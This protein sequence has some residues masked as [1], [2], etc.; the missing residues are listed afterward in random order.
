MLVAEPEVV[1][2]RSGMAVRSSRSDHG[3]MQ[4]INS[5]NNAFKAKTEMK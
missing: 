3:A 2:S 5:K 1:N 4:P